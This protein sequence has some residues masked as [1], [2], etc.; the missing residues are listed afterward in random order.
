VFK[1]RL[2]KVSGDNHDLNTFYNFAQAGL[3]GCAYQRGKRTRSR[4]LSNMIIELVKSCFPP[5]L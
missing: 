3:H 1:I 2:P 4:V 5:A